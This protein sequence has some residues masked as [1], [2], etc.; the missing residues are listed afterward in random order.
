MSDTMDRTSEDF[1]SLAIKLGDLS[2]TL[3]PGE[4]SALAVLLDH[5][6][7]HVVDVTGHQFTAPDEDEVS[8]FS[9]NFNM[10]GPI[11]SVSQYGNVAM[12]YAA[13]GIV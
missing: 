5:A 9:L 6:A 3:T 12:A 8:G 1:E 10:M 13:S 4:Q 2:A 7:S 11:S